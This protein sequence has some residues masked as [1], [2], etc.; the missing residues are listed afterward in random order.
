[1][2]SSPLKSWMA[3]NAEML[4]GKG[5]TLRYSE[6]D[7]GRATLDLDGRDFVGTVSYWPN[8]TLEVLIG[9]A[10]SGRT[11]LIETLTSSHEA[12]LTRVLVEGGII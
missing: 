10:E 11:V 12:E 1:M 5:Y 3:N 9:S 4:E 6:D 7:Q 2:N 8:G